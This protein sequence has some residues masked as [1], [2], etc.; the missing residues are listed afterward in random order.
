MKRLITL[1]LVFSSIMIV[2]ASYQPSHAQNSST[3]WAII[4]LCSTVDYTTV[5]SQAL[6]LNPAEVRNALLSTGS[7][8]DLA[9][10][11]NVDLRNG[12]LAVLN[13]HLSL[14]NQAVQD[15]EMSD[16]DAQQFR[17]TLQA[18]YTSD[19][20]NIGAYNG[21]SNPSPEI[22]PYSFQAVRILPAAATIMNLKCFDMVQRL[23]NDNQSIVALVTAQGGSTGNLIDSILKTYETALDQDVKDG[24]LTVSQAKGLRVQ[25]VQHISV[26]LNQ[27]GP[28][29]AN[30]A[31]TITMGN[32]NSS[33]LNY[34]NQLSL[35]TLFPT[36]Q[37]PPVPRDM[38]IPTKNPTPLPSAT[39]KS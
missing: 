12:T 25:L 14:L 24:L 10:R 26:F 32:L 36:I 1:F 35:L 16:Q 17:S 39:P 27:V 5:V 31:A 38:L 18:I 23:M 8:S 7:L 13:A 34:S 15:S 3:A 21:S 19:P 28:V 30:Q 20:R 4:E 9:Q 33:N 37:L 2:F 22:L 11:K 6:N 29:L